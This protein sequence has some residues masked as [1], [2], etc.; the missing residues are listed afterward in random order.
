MP[1][2]RFSP[3]CVGDQDPALPVHAV[4]DLGLPVV[5]RVKHLLLTEGNPPDHNKKTRSE[6]RFVFLGALFW[7]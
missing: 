4:L 2:Y 3:V 1:G 6:T 7:G 5:P